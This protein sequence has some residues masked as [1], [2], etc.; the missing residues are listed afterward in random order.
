MPSFYSNTMSQQLPLTPPHYFDSF[1]G[2][3]RGAPHLPALRLLGAQ[4]PAY[5]SGRLETREY[6]SQ[7][8][9]YP[10]ASA[11]RAACP[12]ENTRHGTSSYTASSQAPS[13]QYNAASAPM[14]PP[15]RIPERLHMDDFQQQVRTNRAPTVTQPKEEKTVGGV[16]AHLD[17]EMEDMVDFVSQTAQGMYDIY[18]SK[19]CLADI[20]MARSVLTSKSPVHPDLHTYVSQ[21][22]S[23]TRLP[24]ST[25][26]LGLYYL[27]KRMTLLSANGTFNHG[28]GQVYRMLT[29]GLLLG[30]KFLDDNTFQNRSWS[31]VSNIPVSELNTLEVEWL[32]A[33]RWNM[34]INPD[35]PEGFL[36]WRQQWQTFLSHRATR[37]VEQSLAHSLKET[38][39]S[40]GFR[41]QRSVTQRSPPSSG[42]LPSFADYA[43]GNRFHGASQPQWATPR[44][45]PWQSSRPQTEYSPPSA[46]E[47]GPS[48]PQWYGSHDMFTYGQTQQQAYPTLKM[49]PPLQVVGS[50]LP[51][52]G[53]PTPYTHQQYHTYSHLNACG[54]S[55]CSHCVPY[56]DCYLMA[57]G[58]FPQSAVG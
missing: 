23:S 16:A 18:A 17:Y 4:E 36:L 31:E 20:D 24:S 26:I 33:I 47:T 35:D 45:D 49:P 34:H 56:R 15:I 29:I 3:D 8:P 12:Q 5:N 28:S 46:P 57:P 54:C 48:T 44:Y 10:L 58:N 27:A 51:H 7:Y 52:S 37:K 21:V 55:Q 13:T 43:I 11:S 9:Q 41:R 22:L 38:N 42:I 40:N 1:S 32:S 2:G 30:S 14:L 39:L 19:I 53:Y 25:I 50:S 6:K